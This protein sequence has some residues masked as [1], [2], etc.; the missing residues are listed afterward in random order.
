M[1][2]DS[3]KSEV[4]QE[5]QRRIKNLINT[6]QVSDEE[7][8]AIARKALEIIEKDKKGEAVQ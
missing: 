3:E 6:D 2:N 4:L 7:K 1:E 5:L 8:M